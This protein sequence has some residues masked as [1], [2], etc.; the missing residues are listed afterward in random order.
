MAIAQS[1]MKTNAST[2][3]GQ[4]AM[5]SQTITTTPATINVPDAL[6]DMEDIEQVC[7]GGKAKVGG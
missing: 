5:H 6:A 1:A 3:D 4:P 2:V 7:T